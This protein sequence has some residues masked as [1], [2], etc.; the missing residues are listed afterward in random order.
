MGKCVGKFMKIMDAYD[1]QAGVASVS[2][3]HNKKPFFNNLHQV[4]RKLLGANICN[5]S[6]SHNSFSKLKPNVIKTLSQKDLK[7]WVT[8][9]ISKYTSCHEH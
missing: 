8:D 2:R 4:I 1:E 3:T 6:T 9:I 7:E 5:T